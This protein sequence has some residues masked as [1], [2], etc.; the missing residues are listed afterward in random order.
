MNQSWLAGML[1]AYAPWLSD[2]AC[3]GELSIWS[4]TRLSGD[5]SDQRR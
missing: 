1:I 4:M 3:R 5:W 2:T